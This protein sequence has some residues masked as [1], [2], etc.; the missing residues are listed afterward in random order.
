MG[1]KTKAPAAFEPPAA[2][3]A[4]AADAFPVADFLEFWLHCIVVAYLLS[5]R[6]QYFFFL[7]TSSASSGSFAR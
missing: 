3:F 5:F 2:A 1:R 4:P 7:L 6:I